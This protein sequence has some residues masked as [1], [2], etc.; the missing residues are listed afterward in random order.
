MGESIETKPVRKIRSET[1]RKN[2][3]YGRDHFFV[4]GHPTEA[5][6]NFTARAGITEAD[7]PED[8]KASFQSCSCHGSLCDW[9]FY[10]WGLPMEWASDRIQIEVKALFPEAIVT[11]T[12]S[13]T[14]TRAVPC[15][16]DNRRYRFEREDVLVT[17]DECDAE[18]PHSELESDSI[19]YEGGYSDAV[20]P[21][22]G[23]WDC[24]TWEDEVLSDKELEAL[25]E[26]NLTVAEA[27]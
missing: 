5:R 22:C 4:S 12:P 13:T 1:V 8:W 23:E 24:A 10:F 18:F 6:A 19:D 26:E 25:A 17:C 21:K 15:S 2:P 27:E 20:C 3:D 9:E 7:F 11:A 14:P 16:P